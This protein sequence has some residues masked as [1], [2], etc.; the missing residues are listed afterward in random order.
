MTVI[1]SMKMSMSVVLAALVFHVDLTAGSSGG[2][3]DWCVGVANGGCQK[4]VR[5][6]QC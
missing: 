3:F 5:Q 2:H 1:V 4:S 6:K